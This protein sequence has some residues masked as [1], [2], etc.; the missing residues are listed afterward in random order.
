MARA[1]IRSL[2][3]A[4]V[5]TAR[6]DQVSYARWMDLKLTWTLPKSPPEAAVRGCKVRVGCRR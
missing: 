3:L 4:A 2:A 6:K 5:T 1:A